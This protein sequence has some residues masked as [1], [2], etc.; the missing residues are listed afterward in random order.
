MS[1][2]A[3]VGLIAIAATVLVAVVGSYVLLSNKVTQIA[4]ILTRM[5]QRLDENR[6]DHGRIW[7]RLED[8]GE[9]I[10]R[11]EPQPRKATP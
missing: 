11:L 5:E 9:R 3:W 4:T 10:T 7:D 2:E 6:E 1:A 8:H